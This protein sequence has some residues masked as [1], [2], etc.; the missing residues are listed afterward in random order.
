MAPPPL[1][2]WILERTIPSRDRDAILGDLV[3]EFAARG[4][5]ARAWL[6]RQALGSI[7]PL[8]TAGLARRDR[9]SLAL[10]FAIGYLLFAV[11]LLALEWIRTFVLSQVPFRA[12]AEPGLPWL[13][14]IV[15]ANAAGLL[16]G[17]AL[18]LRRLRS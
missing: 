12:G 18:A 15:A 2:I 16:T 1:P 10:H 17:A 14:L 5:G 11:P 8:M 13:L 3:E 7:V 4:A 9:A 6:W